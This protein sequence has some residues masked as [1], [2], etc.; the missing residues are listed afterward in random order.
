MCNLGGHDIDLLV[1][2]FNSIDHDRP[3]CFIAYTIKGMGLPLAGHKDN[4]S[5]LMTLKQMEGFRANMNVREGHEWDLFEGLEHSE[6]EMRA[7]LDKVPFY[8]EG[9]RR[10][11]GNSQSR[12]PGACCRDRCRRPRFNRTDGRGR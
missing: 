6:A 3:V 8:K 12:R 11:R 5:G 1:D 9:R 4:H 2:T 7:F 10:F